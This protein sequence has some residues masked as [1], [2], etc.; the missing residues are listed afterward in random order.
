VFIIDSSCIP[1][2]YHDINVYCVGTYQSNPDLALIESYLN[3]MNAQYYEL[4]GTIM[5]RLQRPLMSNRYS[6][7]HSA[8]YSQGGQQTKMPI[9]CRIWWDSTLDAYTVSSSY[10]EKLV[11]SLKQFIPSGSRD[12]DPQTKFWYVKEQYGEFIKQ[13]AEAAFGVGSVSFTSRNVTQQSQSGPQAYQAGPRPM[14]PTG[15]QT[16]EDCI[17]AMFNLIPY[18]SAKKA[19]L[20]ASSIL[21]PDK[22]TGDGVKMT[23]LNELWSRI[24]KEFYKR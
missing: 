21:H 24:E 16:T 20:H 1:L 15:T 3:P 2:G 12:F 6:R 18:D 22:P 19:Y 5:W 13:I 10:S 8:P 23:K 14:T 17:V 7:P 4:R 9:K 11:N